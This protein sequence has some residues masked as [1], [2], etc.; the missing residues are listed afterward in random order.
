MDQ[1]Q[2]S[3]VKE[4]LHILEENS[5]LSIDTLASMLNMPV[6]SVEQMIAELKQ[7][8]VIVKYMALVNW[9]KLEENDHVTAVIDVK[10][11]PKRDVGFDEVAE[12]I[13][14]FPEVKSVYLMS[15]AY[16]LSVTI[17]ARTMKEIAQFVSDK[18]STLDSVISTTTHFMLKRYK[19]DG[20]VLTDGE[21]DK[22]MVVTP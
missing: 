22:R 8:N 6:E 1:I 21:D 16:D 10:V 3:K 18:L 11:T 20:V 2:M 12:R 4:L 7:K 5:D 13:Y 15:G 17:E 14:R 19:H 9:D